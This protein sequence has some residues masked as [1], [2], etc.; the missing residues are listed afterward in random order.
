MSR[1]AISEERA[2]LAQS[3]RDLAD[4]V[5]A[6]PDIPIYS[7]VAVI[8][9]DYRDRV[10]QIVGLAS[11]GFTL[12]GSQQRLKIGP[13]VDV[14]SYVDKKFLTPSIVDGEVVYEIPE[15]VAA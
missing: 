6:N 9:S 14:V 8:G 13:G 3:I 12:D 15:Q 11:R 7:A 2:A 5:E 4:Y 1:Q 10:G